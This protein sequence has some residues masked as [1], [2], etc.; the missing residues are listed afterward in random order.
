MWIKI[1]CIEYILWWILTT[2]PVFDVAN[3]LKKNKWQNVSGN[4]DELPNIQACSFNMSWKMGCTQSLV[5]GCR[6]Q[7]VPTISTRISDYSQATLLH[8][9]VT[10]QKKGSQSKWPNP[11]NNWDLLILC[12]TWAC[13][14]LKST[15]APSRADPVVVF[16]LCRWCPPQETSQPHPPHQVL[17]SLPLFSGPHVTFSTTYHLPY[18]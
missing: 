11:K 8:H 15:T 16:P 2:K 13:I 3:M 12:T 7:E 17:T 4:N 6:Y 9:N 18:W 5:V 14:W 10:D 1:L